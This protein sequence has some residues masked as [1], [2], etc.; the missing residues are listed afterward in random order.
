MLTRRY[1]RNPSML[2]AEQCVSLAPLEPHRP[3]Q[4]TSDRRI[5]S[6]RIR[7]CIVSY[8]ASLL[9]QIRFEHLQRGPSWRQL[10]CQRQCRCDR[11][12]AS[13]DGVIT[14][15]SNQGL[16]CRGASVNLIHAYQQ[17]MSAGAVVPPGGKSGETGAQQSDSAV[18]RNKSAGTAV[19]VAMPRR[20]GS[21]QG[22]QHPK[23]LM[24]QHR[25]S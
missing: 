14:A 22:A 8:D 7:Y 25:R 2:M 12:R 24:S 3:S 1:T 17:C 13:N 4:H 6:M 21:H 15:Q 9:L 16:S 19:R 23:R 5:L 20:R 11:H 18:E 10:L